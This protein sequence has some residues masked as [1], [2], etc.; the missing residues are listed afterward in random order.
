MCLS[1]YSS[2]IVFSFIF[3]SLAHKNKFSTTHNYLQVSKLY[4]KFQSAYQKGHSCETALIKVVSDIQSEISKKKMVALVALDLSSAFDTIDKDVLL[5]KLDQDFK[6]TGTVL[7]WIRSYLSGRTF[8]VR[9]ATIDGK[10]VLLIYGV[11]QG[12]IL[13]P[14][15]FILYIHDIVPIAEFYGLCIHLYADDSNLCI[16]FNPLTEASITMLHIN[17]SLN[18]IKQWMVSNFLRI[19]IDKTD[20][21]FLAAPLI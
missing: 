15:L 2:L 17:N 20:G 14:L 6:I 1:L 11:P 9:I 19:N 8:A 13:G 3:L 4:P 7:A 5:C 18:D 16:G 12:S 21:M 10:P